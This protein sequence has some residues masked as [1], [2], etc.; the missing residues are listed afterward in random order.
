[1]KRIS[2]LKLLSFNNHVDERGLF[3]ET[4]SLKKYSGMGIDVE[5]VQDNFSFS[6]NTGT[7]RGLHFQFPP[8]AQAKLVSCI[9]GAIFDVAVD[10]R[11]GSPTFGKWEAYQLT[12]SN[13]KQ[14]FV[15]IGFAHG[16][17]T[18]EPDS[19]VIYKCSNYYDPEKE[20]SILWNDPNLAI[21]WPLDRKPIVNE[22]DS[23]ASAF[24]V[25]RTPFIYGV[26]S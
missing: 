22:K 26:N 11:K 12:P 8:K 3:A 21:E 6:R 10:I 15:P 25:L 20:C 18:L 7:L 17:L 14:L 24:K 5:F 23:V 2:S 13:G 1:M 4:Y 9:R 16:F 19:E